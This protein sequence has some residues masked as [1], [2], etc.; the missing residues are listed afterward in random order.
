[1]LAHG[2][3]PLDTEWW[4]F[5]LRDELEFSVSAKKKER[6]SFVLLSTFCNFALR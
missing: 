4:H 6:D 3:K 5:T 1:M 2:F